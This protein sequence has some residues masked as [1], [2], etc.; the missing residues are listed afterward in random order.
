M[1]DQSELAFR[2]LV[3]RYGAQLCYTP[4]YNSKLFATSRWADSK[5]HELF[6]I[7]RGAWPGG[8]TTDILTV[9]ATLK[10]T[11]KPCVWPLTRTEQPTHARAKASDADF[12]AARRTPN[13]P[14]IILLVIIT[15]MRATEAQV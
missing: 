6:R 14:R 13:F 5:V 11:F 2:R 9:C 1:V 10:Y 7:L 15:T 3:R 4:M 12:R 8:P